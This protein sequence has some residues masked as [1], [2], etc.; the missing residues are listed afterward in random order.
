MI[1][2][3]C[4]KDILGGKFVQ[5]EVQLDVNRGFYCGE[6]TGIEELFNALNEATIASLAGN[7]VVDAAVN[8]GFVDEE[9]VLEIA[10][11]KHAQIVVMPTD[12]R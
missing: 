5:G 11:I 8:R 1:V 2:A 10:G 3:A 12:Y 7:N 9:N 6:L 4:D